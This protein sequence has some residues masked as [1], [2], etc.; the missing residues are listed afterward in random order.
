MITAPLTLTGALSAASTAI[1]AA[2]SE[3]AVSTQNIANASTPMYAREQVDL[4]AY[5]NDAGVEVSNIERLVSPTIR[6]SLISAQGQQSGA[7]ESSQ[8]LSQIQALFGEPGNGLST[9]LTGFWN[10]WQQVANS[11]SNPGARDALVSATTQLTTQFNSVA[12][13]LTNLQQSL[14]PAIGQQID[15]VNSLAQQVANLNG[16]ITTGTAGGLSVNSLEDQRDQLVSQLADLVG[17]APS[18]L[19]TGQPTVVVNGQPLVVGT[20]VY[21]LQGTTTPTSVNVAWA[22]NGQPANLTGGQLGA[23]IQAATDQ[24]PAVQGQLNA[25]AAGLIQAVNTQSEAGYTLDTPPVTGVAF[26]QGTGAGDIAINPAI[27]AS[28]NEIAA[29]ASGAPGDGANAQAIANLATAAGAAGTTI[30]QQYNALV[31]QV[32]T[33]LATAN[34]GQTTANNQVTSFQQLD[35]SVSGVSTSDEQTA[36]LLDESQ[37]QAASAVLQA[38]QTMLNGL[39]TAVGV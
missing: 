4:T 26:F 35:Q 34:Q 29:S 17:A 24:I 18:A 11:P 36:L 23:E 5:S 32:G 8:L 27:S 14:I 21:A 1:D 30:T 19:P 15:Q 7:A 9:L 12:D 25:V 13:G 28:T 37:S 2:S 39:L 33:E 6:S 16:Q 3:A 10:A 20:T 31:V 38:V 22:A